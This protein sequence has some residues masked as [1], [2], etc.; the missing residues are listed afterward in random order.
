MSQ[1]AKHLLNLKRIV[2]SYDGQLLNP[3]ERA[4]VSLAATAVLVDM[5]AAVIAGTV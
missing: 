3:R 1:A 5:S 4:F 2:E